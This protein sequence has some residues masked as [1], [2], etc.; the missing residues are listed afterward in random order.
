MDEDTDGL[1]AET[2]GELLEDEYVRSILVETNIEPVSANE[3]AERCEASEPTIYRRF[4]RLRKLDMIEEKQALDP[5]GHHYK[6]FAARLERVTVKLTDG[7]Y[8]VTVDRATEDAVNSFTELY[9]DSDDNTRTHC[10]GRIDCR[11]RRRY[12]AGH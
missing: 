5:D 11:S 7:G 3:L 2:V 10:R 9:E 4:N 12:P 8:E 6:L 1:N